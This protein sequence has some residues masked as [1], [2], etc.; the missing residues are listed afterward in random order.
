MIGKILAA[1]IGKKAAEQS[2]SISGPGGALLG[3]ATATLARRL[4]PIGLIALAAGGYALK[5][6]LE[7]RE[8]TAA[9][10]A[11]APAPATGI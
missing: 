3:V 11:A 9:A 6:R 2:N 4:S 8:R 1:V 10:P 7:K 5:R